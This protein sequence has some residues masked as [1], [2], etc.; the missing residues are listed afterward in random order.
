MSKSGVAGRFT[1]V[2]RGDGLVG[3][4]AVGPRGRGFTLVELM[5][6]LAIMGLLGAAVA[7]TLPAQGS[8]LADDA[9]ALAARLQRAQQEAILGTRAL[10]VRADARGYAFSV[11]RFD[12]WQPLA[13][14]PFRPAAWS[15][16]VAPELPRGREAVEF[17]F[18]PIGTAEPVRIVLRQDRRRAQVTVEATG[19][20]EVATMPAGG[21]RMVAENGPFRSAQ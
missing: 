17:R 6:V 2:G 18:D 12:G 9:D 13:D 4:Q 5:V 11:Q 8:A 21:H 20:V 3:V 7:L 10:R 16:G 1:V 15:D 19:E 14:A